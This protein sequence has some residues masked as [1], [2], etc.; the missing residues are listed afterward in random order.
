MSY[1]RPPQFLEDQKLE[2]D[3]NFRRELI[4]RHSLYTQIYEDGASEQAM[5]PFKHDFNDISYQK[6]YELK[7]M[8]KFVMADSIGDIEGLG[9]QLGKDDFEKE[10]AKDK[11]ALEYIEEDKYLKEYLDKKGGKIKCGSL[12]YIQGNMAFYH[13]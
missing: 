1:Q 9:V 8:R 10:I 5:I 11:K 7:Y 6:A 4:K 13:A 12:S 2:T 3:K